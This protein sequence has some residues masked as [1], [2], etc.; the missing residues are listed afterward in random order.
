MIYE[1]QHARIGIYV[2]IAKLQERL[3][4]VEDPTVLESTFNTLKKLNETL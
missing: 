1:T 2:Q 4:E 3:R